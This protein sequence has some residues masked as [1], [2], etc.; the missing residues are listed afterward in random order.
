MN[1]TPA[2]HLNAGALPGD[3]PYLAATTRWL[4]HEELGQ[5]L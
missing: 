4:A 5:Q 1:P 3:A 2:N